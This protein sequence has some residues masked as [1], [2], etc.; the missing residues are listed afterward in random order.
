[1]AAHHERATNQE[2]AEEICYFSG[3][4][5]EIYDDHEKF[6]ISIAAA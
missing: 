6:A 2:I 4:N 1:M 3:R 5:N